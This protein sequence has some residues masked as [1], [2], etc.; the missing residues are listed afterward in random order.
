MQGICEGASTSIAY[1]CCGSILCSHRLHVSASVNSR[2]DI[3]I[4]A[5]TMKAAASRGNVLADIC[6]I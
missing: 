2:E 3:R 1:V 4:E 5:N 6:I